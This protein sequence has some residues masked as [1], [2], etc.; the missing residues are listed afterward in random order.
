MSEQQAET[1]KYTMGLKVDGSKDYEHVTIAYLDENKPDFKPED[2]KGLKKVR[3]EI[4]MDG[5][6]GLNKD[7]NV[8]HVNV[9]ESYPFIFDLWKKYNVEEEVTKGLTVPVLHIT[10]K[11]GAE[12]RKIGDILTLSTLFVKQTGRHDP[13]FELKLE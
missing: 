5:W 2:F 6:L 3:A 13:Y 9:L 11:K 8:W 4:F 12:E 1:P 7:V 10:K